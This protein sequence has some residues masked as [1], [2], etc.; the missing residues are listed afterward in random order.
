MSSPSARTGRLNIARS[1]AWRPATTARSPFTHLSGDQ[2]PAHILNGDK[3]STDVAFTADWSKPT[4]E[5]LKMGTFKVDT[6][7]A[8]QSFTVTRTFQTKVGWGDEE[9]DLAAILDGTVTWTVTGPG[10]TPELYEGTG[11]HLI[12]YNVPVTVTIETSITKTTVHDKNPY[13]AIFTV[14]DP[15]INQL[16]SGSITKYGGVQVTDK[17]TANHYE[18]EFMFTE[19]SDLR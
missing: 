3:D 16:V 17:R 1:R 10:I 13:G 5:T 6:S 12:P 4:N 7:P 8:I 15:M 18:V 14:S 2:Y 19:K 11:I 9:Y